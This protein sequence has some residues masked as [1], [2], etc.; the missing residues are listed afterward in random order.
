MIRF[1]KTHA[2]QDGASLT[3]RSG[4]SGHRAGR[5]AV[6]LDGEIIGYVD[7]RGVGSSASWDSQDLAGERTPGGGPFSSRQEAAEYLIRQVKR[8]RI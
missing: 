3:W 5:Y 8:G 2:A 6:E 1:L 7:G 4:G